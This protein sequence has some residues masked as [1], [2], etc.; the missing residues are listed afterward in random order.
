MRYIISMLV[1]VVSTVLVLSSVCSAFTTRSSVLSTSRYAHQKV[2]PP[3]SRV[4]ATI[5]AINNH[6]NDIN[7]ITRSSTNLH[8]ARNND[9]EGTDRVLACLPYIIP[10]LELVYT[11]V[12]VPEMCVH[13][14]C[15]MSNSMFTVFTS[16]SFL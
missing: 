8:M 10:L 12:H 5:Q 6:G 11:C 1:R 14:F 16:A 7:I 9:I 2:R 15:S 3:T 13:F 4:V